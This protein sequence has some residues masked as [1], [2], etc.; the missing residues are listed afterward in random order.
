MAGPWLPELPDWLTLEEL[1][2]TGGFDGT[3][4]NPPKGLIVPVGRYDIPAVPGTGRAGTGL[5]GRRTLRRIRL[6]CDRKD[7]LLKDGTGGTVP[8]T[9]RLRR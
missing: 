3:S 8:G 6:E 7:L 1:G 9:I 2:V 5:Y 4:W